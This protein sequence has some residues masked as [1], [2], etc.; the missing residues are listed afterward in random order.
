MIRFR[1]GFRRLCPVLQ[2]MLITQLLGVALSAQ[3][4]DPVVLQKQ[5]E[6]R[7]IAVAGS[8]PEGYGV[9]LFRKS[10]EL[11]DPPVTFP[12]Y[13]SADNRYKLF[14]N[15]KLVSVGPAKGDIKHWYFE[16]VDLGPYLTAGKNIIAALVWN[17]GEQRAVAQISLRTGFILRGATQEAEVLNTGTSWRCT[18]DTSYS[19]LRVMVMGYYVAGPGQQVDMNSNIRGWQGLSF[20]DSSWK[21]ATAIS[22]G[23]PKYTVGL[24]GTNTWMLMPSTIPGPEMREE[25][26]EKVRRA[27]SVSVPEAFM[28]GA[29]PLTIPAG[30]RATIL[31]DQDHLT[32]AFVSLVFSGGKGS[33]ITLTYAEGLTSRGNNKGNRNEIEGKR[34]SGRR[35][36]V[37]SDGTR[38]QYFTTLTY[39]TFRYIQLEVETTGSPLVIEDIYGTFTGYPFKFNARLE[40]DNT[41]MLQMLDIGW[42]T[43]RLCAMDTYMDCPY[44]EQLQYVGDTRIQA[45]VSLYNSGD[46]R[47]VR[48]ALNLI[49]WSRQPEGVTLSRYP[50]EIHQFIPTFSLWYIGMLYDYMMYGNDTLFVKDKLPGIRQI[51]HYFSGFQMSDGSL[52]N[53]PYWTFTDWV[54]SPGWQRG[55]GPSGKDGTSAILDLQLLMAYQAAEKMEE[56]LGMAD[57]ATLCHHKSD[58]LMN[59]IRSRYWDQSRGLFADTHE[60]D[61]FSQHTNSLAILTGLVNA[62]EA[63]EIGHKL[64]SDTTMAPASI[65]FKYYLHQALVRAGMGD[66]YLSWLDIWR[67]NIELGMTTWG[68]DSQVETTR[69]DCHAWGS[70][71]NIE[72][73]RTILGIDSDAPGFRRVKI[74]PHLGS[75]EKIGG[76]M[77]HPAG[78]IKVSYDNS[79]NRL[80]AEITFPEG[81]KGTFIWQGIKYDLNAGRNVIRI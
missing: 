47:L 33:R 81:I 23:T 72:F 41:E 28:A 13:V 79:G 42:R 46:D 31:L 21:N 43:A 61:L 62:R 22:A 27:E 6:A 60:K 1:F 29:A 58:Q 39:R 75:I 40:T 68:E 8:E 53:V 25:R 5:W 4:L 77:P 36:M 14:I 35:D 9:Y 63:T 32:N 12:V 49:D 76:E 16:T 7:W 59:T 52:C 71:P 37:I 55:R 64:L 18:R 73:F 69:S 78:K 65:Y 19:P 26:L 38:D 30:T 2:M 10:F 50:S 70:S 34:I 51:L 15:E 80:N 48:N 3:S 56:V 17:E 74:E 66:D 67:R 45:L 54:N 11:T 57:H 44:Y 24:D 20:D